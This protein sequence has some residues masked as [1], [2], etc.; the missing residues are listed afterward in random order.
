[1]A[2][3]SRQGGGYLLAAASLS[4]ATLVSEKTSAIVDGRQRPPSSQSRGTRGVNANP[5]HLATVFESKGL[6]REERVTSGSRL[7]GRF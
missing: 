1:M 4:A 2:I 5:R 7:N 6:L 3:S